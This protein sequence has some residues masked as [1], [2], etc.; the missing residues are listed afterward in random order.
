[1]LTATKTNYSFGAATVSSRGLAPPKIEEAWVV[2]AS[3][4]KGALSVRGW[5]IS[6]GRLLASAITKGFLCT[7]PS[8]IQ[9]N[10]Y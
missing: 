5:S 8:H 7:K 10:Y 3:W 4:F 9:F 2:S 1:M 6:L